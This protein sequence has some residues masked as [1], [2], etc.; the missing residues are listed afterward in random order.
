VSLLCGGYVD[1]HN[2]GVIVCVDIPRVLAFLA[3][4]ITEVLCRGKGIA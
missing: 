2:I 1:S 4:I 3:Y